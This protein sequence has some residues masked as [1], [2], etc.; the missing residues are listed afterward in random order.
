MAGGRGERFW[1]LSRTAFPK[2]FLSLVGEKTMLQQTVERLEGIV[3][4]KDVYVVAGEEF[5][6]IIRQ[7]LPNLPDENIVIEP[8]GRD[9]A[10]AI[11]LA[12][13]FVKRK[14]PNDVMIVLP[15][16][17]FIRDLS[18]FKE[19]ILGAIE[20]AALGGDVVTLGIT[21]NRPE[22]GY[23][24]I[25]SGGV[26]RSL[27]GL[28]ARKVRHFAEKPDYDT[29]VRFISDGDYLW[30]S[31]MFVWRV[32]LIDALI[33]KHTPELAIGL[34]LI[35]NALGT[36]EYEQILKEIYQDLPRISV[37][38]GI[39]EKAERVLVIPSDFGWDDLGSWTAL[40]N[41]TQKDSHN[42][43]LMGRGVLLETRNTSVYAKGQTVTTIGV[44]DLIVVYD[45][46][47]LL[48]CHKEK[49]QEVRKAV[50]ALKEN[51]CED[52]L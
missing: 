29:A 51:G 50:Q 11:G 25:R 39:M 43:V 41:Y 23:G 15:A 14:N 44:T 32:D 47:S 52:V 27:P 36:P 28:E 3:E 6:G 17:H 4:T 34:H 46:G 49:A 33:K 2:Q 19:I 5:K 22:T 48:I 37:D 35:E 12:T 21:P 31:G 9:T 13:V 45:N 30:N 16:D 18:R 40:E 42:N 26:V 38:Y 20:T 1:P 7:Q 24:Y 10:A 8:F